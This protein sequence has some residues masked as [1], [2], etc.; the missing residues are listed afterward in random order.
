MEEKSAAKMSFEVTEAAV[1]AAGAEKS[2]KSTTRGKG[3]DAGAAAMTVFFFLEGRGCAGC[4][5]GPGAGCPG[6]AGPSSCP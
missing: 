2:N 3:A 6:A 4:A 1:V 5:A